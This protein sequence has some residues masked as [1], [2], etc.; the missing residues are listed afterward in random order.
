MGF[1]KDTFVFRVISLEVIKR[2]YKIKIYNKRASNHEKKKCRYVENIR[3][4][5]KEISC[6][7]VQ[8]FKMT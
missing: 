3:T 6:A 2:N 5:F 1:K 4:D 7:D 8:W